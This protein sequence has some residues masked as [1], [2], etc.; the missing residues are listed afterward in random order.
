MV[1]AMSDQIELQWGR[2]L[3]TPEIGRESA[4]LRPLPPLQW[5]RGLKT[6]EISAPPT[7]AANLPRLQ[8]GRGLKTP[9]I[10]AEWPFILR[11]EQASM[12]PGS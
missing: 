3:K 7:R 2:G 10:A 11:A 4:A 6:P 8:W 5:G 12:G 9:E 1:N